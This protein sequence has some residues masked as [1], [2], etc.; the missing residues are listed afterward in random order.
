[1]ITASSSVNAVCTS[2]SRRR[3]ERASRAWL[4][5]KLPV[6]AS[7]RSGILARILP[8]AMFA[9]TTGSDSPS[10]IA[11]SINRAETVFRLDATLDSL[12]LASS[13]ISSSRVTSRVRSPISCTR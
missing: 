1:V 3:I 8:W 11:A 12:M 6:S 7:T 2:S 5:S 4:T 9:N 10:I 13:S